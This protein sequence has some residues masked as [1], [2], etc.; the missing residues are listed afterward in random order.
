MD[1]VIKHPISSS[2]RVGSKHRLK[3]YIN[4]SS[5]KYSNGDNYK[6]S[7]VFQHNLDVYFTY[8]GREH[9]KPIRTLQ[10]NKQ[11]VRGTR[12]TVTRQMRAI[13]KRHS[14]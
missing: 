7:R 6:S 10:I 13:L 2:I 9:T 5:F 8:N 4:K 11:D 3:S 1:H 12:G 14:L